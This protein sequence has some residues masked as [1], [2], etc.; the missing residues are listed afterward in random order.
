MPHVTVH[1]PRETYERVRAHLLPPRG[2]CEEAA[3]LYTTAEVSPESIRLSVVD[4]L[5][6]PP[7]G[8]ASRSRFYL[9][10]VDATRAAVIKHAHDL[11]AGLIEC[12]SHPGQ[13]G[14]CFSWSDLHGFDDFVP[15]VRWRLAGRPYA[16]IVFATDSVDA[17]AWCGKTHDAVPIAAVHASNQV[18]Q[19]TGS[20]LQNWSDIYERQPL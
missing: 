8:F 17:L 19:P 12:H 7:D 18:V 10:L 2:V 9:E 20:T 4:A 5:L 15:H 13:R 3:F 14:A 1:M 6:I 16:A 11:G